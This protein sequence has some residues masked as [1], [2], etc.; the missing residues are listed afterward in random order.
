MSTV[1]ST[2][3]T[4]VHTGR[5]LSE[6]FDA[7]F[8]DR[9]A[10][11]YCRDREF[12]IRAGDLVL[13]EQFSNK[14]N[15]YLVNIVA[16]YFRSYKSSPSKEFIID[17]IKEAKKRGKI[18]EEFVPEVV[19]AMKRILAE[20]LEDTGYMIDRVVTFARSVAFDDAFIKAAELKEKGEFERAMQVMQKVDLVGASDMDDVY[21]YLARAGERHERREYEASEDFIPNSITTGIPLLDKM[22]HQKGWGRK[23][24]VLFMGFAKSGKSTAMGEFGIN[25]TLKGYN[26]LYVSLEVHKDILSDRWDARISETEMSKL[27]ERRDDIADKLRSIGAGSKVGSMWIVERRANTFSPADLDRLLSNMKANGMMP[28]MVIVD[29]ADLM[30]AT[31][32]T[33]DPRNDVK[34]I[35]TDLRA[36]MDKHDVAGMTA[37]QT[38]REGGASEV[39]T[40]MHA[41]D[42][43]E[44]VRICDLI[45]SINK[46]EEEEAKGEARL[47]FAGSRNQKGGVSLRVLQDLE[48]MR[49]IKRII[50]VM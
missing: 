48:Q 29:Y 13:P 30:R 44:K 27:I 20:K 25:A 21:D 16:G 17:M 45:I 40:M 35:Y 18:R 3:E 7:G 36:V 47:Y 39:A 2:F 23:E 10:A 1:S 42:N 6:E 14:A 9:L 15:G 49:F 28:D 12:L 41:A 11:Y 8:E 31:T 5:P 37:S 43:I 4:P 22:L 26:V 24:L 34:D 32:P 19:E 46:T 33:K 50:D 38:N